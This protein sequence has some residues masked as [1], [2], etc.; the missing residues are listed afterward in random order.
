MRRIIIGN[1]KL[2]CGEPCFVIAEAGVNHNGN[3]DMGLKLV[4]VAAD[5]GADAVKF[6][7]FKTEQL[8]TRTA[9]KAAYQQANTNSIESQFDM[10]RQLELSQEA[11]RKIAERAAE[12]KILFLSTPF[13]M[14]S[15]DFL[16]Q[17]GVPAFKVPSG[18]ITN[19]PFLQYIARKGKPIILSTGM[20]FLGDVET[21]VRAIMAT[22][23][24]ELVLLHC[25][26]NYPA[27]PND[28]NLRA[29]HTMGQ[30]FNVPIG[31]SDHTLGNE[32]PFAAVAMGACIIEK[33]FTLDCELPGP[34]HKASSTPDELRALIRGI[35]VIEASL[36]TGRKECTISEVST[37]AVARRSLVAARDLPSDTLLTDDMVAI[38]R[39]G[40]GLP[41][42]MLPYL[43]GRR[44]RVSVQRGDILDIG[45]LG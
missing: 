37:A 7:T 4:D 29:M 16:A 33:H 44:L 43:L 11:Y 13:D 20:S 32:I 35:R 27:A 21:A 42:T 23:N 30:A 15:A 9:P 25:V 40:T 24:S 14:A 3:L 31:Y 6:Q 1:K 39:P 41:P 19:I 22:G 45:M 34:D 10:I 2:G 18:E 5:A 26:S 12:R 36:G 38:L 8:V 17:L 28:I